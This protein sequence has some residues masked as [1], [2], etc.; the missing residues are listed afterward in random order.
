MSSTSII[1]DFEINNDLTITDGTIKLV[2][3]DANNSFDFSGNITIGTL[4]STL[5]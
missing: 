2:T 1:N 3:N 5:H 4:N